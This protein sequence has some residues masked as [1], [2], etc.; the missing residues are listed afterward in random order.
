M[1]SIRHTVITLLA[2]VIVYALTG[3]IH[4][5]PEGDGIDPTLVQAGIELSIDINWETNNV[6]FT[7]AQDKAFRIVIEM[8]RNNSSVGKCMHLLSEEEYAAGQVKLIM[9][10]KLHAVSYKVTA[11]LDAVESVGEDEFVYDIA[12]L[13][14]IRRSDNHISWND[15]EICATSTTD[16]NLQGYKDQWGA[17]VIIPMKLTTPLGRFQIVATDAEKFREF[18]SE[19][20]KRGE[21]YSI[22]LSF[23]NRISRG[24]NACDKEIAGYLESP[25]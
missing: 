5:Y 20:V 9:P 13:S 24:F 2:F 18:V 19:S 6:N 16:V 1:K 17:N 22:C 21:S 25:E 10:F 7:K 8:T 12:N 14:E 15:R 11:W 4:T 23:E 3:C